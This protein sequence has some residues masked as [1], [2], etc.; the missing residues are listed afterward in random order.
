ME[1]PEITISSEDINKGIEFLVKEYKYFNE[2]NLFIEDDGEDEIVWIKYPGEFEEFREFSFDEFDFLVAKLNGL[3]IIS[4]GR[5]YTT[6][7]SYQI[8]RFENEDIQYYLDSQT[9]FLKEFE[10]GTIKIIYETDI[11]PFISIKL[12]AYHEEYG[13]LIDNHPSIQIEYNDKRNR[14]SVKNET[15]LILSY[16]FEISDST[17]YD[18]SLGKFKIPNKELFEEIVKF[19]DRNEAVIFKLKPLIDFNEG[20]ELFIS[21]LQVNDE[22]LKFLNFYKI[23]EYFAPIIIRLEGNSLLVSKLDNPKSL[24]P[25][26]Q[27]IDSIFDL[28]NSV[29]ENQK[30]SELA[31]VVLKHIDII[32]SIELLPARIIRHSIAS[33]KV[34][35][36]NYQTPKE[37]LT[38]IISVI[39][40][41]LYSTRNWVV[42][43]KSNYQLTGKEFKQEEME[44][45]NIFMKQITAKL[46]RW[47]DKLP[48]HHK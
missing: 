13:T 26:R 44:Q 33:A 15:Q 43:A 32:D 3:K 35:D 30:D 21:A 4:E 28:V 18:I 12:D 22:A 37:K 38:I 45:L 48:K 27:Y 8:I 20:M 11:L 1:E 6:W 16:L 5:F 34:K 7:C 41:A 10:L 17:G 24:N 47:Y 36:I 23:I 29:K 9:D 2:E 25:D 19:G 31:K 14:L 42:H 40:T 46:I 39:A